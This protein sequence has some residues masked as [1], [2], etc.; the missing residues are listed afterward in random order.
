MDAFDLARLL[1]DQN[2]LAK[3]YFEFLR[4]PSLSMGIYRLAEGASDLQSPHRE[5]EVYVVLEGK[6]RISV[7]EEDRPVEKGSIV[8]VERTVPHRFHSIEED[9]RVLV[10][11]APAESP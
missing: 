8:F 3:P 2:A 1:E 6:A 9:L 4:K 5:D 10:F 7:G 11:F